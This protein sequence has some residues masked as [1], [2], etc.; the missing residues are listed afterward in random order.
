MAPRPTDANPGR[1]HDDKAAAFE[2]ARRRLLSIAHRM[3]NSR[4]EAEDIVQETWLRWHH[5]DRDALRTPVAW[6]TTVA[7]RLAIDR[8]RELQRELEQPVAGPW[9]PEPWDD[10]TA[11]PADSH[12]VK[13]SDLTYGLTLMFD[14]LSPEERAALLLYEAFDC[15]H[16]EIARVLCKEVAACR[17]IVH[18]AKLRVQRL[19][20]DMTRA[21]APRPIPRVVQD[22]GSRP[23]AH[24]FDDSVSRPGTGRGAAGD[25]ASPGTRNAGHDRESTG[26]PRDERDP[27]DAWRLA[28]CGASVQQLC[29]AI[30][31]QDKAAVIELL[32]GNE[33]VDAVARAS[34]GALR[35]ADSMPVEAHDLARVTAQAGFIASHQPPFEALT[36]KT[37]PFEIATNRVE[38]ER[39]ATHWIAWTRAGGTV[40]A[41]SLDARPGLAFIDGCEIVYA[42]GFALRANGLVCCI[43]LSEAAALRV[44]NDAYDPLR[45]LRMARCCEAPVA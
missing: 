39:V 20:A 13:R 19:H 35:S 6:L 4:A 44:L 21:L 25:H 11:P 2:A 45:A 26:A 34:E 24:P 18:R 15:S 38:A 41:I 37:G 7:T 42:I 40:E 10:K 14:G 22:I 17:Q 16:R 3:L 1:V 30:A 31:A 28:E 9:L 23:T 8:L 43:N 32:L 29:D 33:Y 36:E 12:V 5:A 27:T